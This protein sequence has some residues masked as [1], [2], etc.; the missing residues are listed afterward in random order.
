MSSDL[1]PASTAMAIGYRACR[2]CR[3][4]AR[5]PAARSSTMYQITQLKGK[6]SPLSHAKRQRWP[7]RRAPQAV[8]EP[9]ASQAAADRP[10]IQMPT[11]LT[12]QRYRARAGG[13]APEHS[14]KSRQT[15]SGLP[16]PLACALTW[17]NSGQLAKGSAVP[18][19]DILLSR[20]RA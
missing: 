15:S 4:V 19:L 3:L 5:P 10:S 16:V 13:A 20:V 14:S 18:L 6:N 8:S 2:R 12:P 17:P 9:T 1:Y 7:R 11:A